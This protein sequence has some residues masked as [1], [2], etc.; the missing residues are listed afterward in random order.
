MATI[1]KIL[2]SPLAALSGAFKKPAKAPVAAPPPVVTRNAAAENAR[3]YDELRKRRG[4]GANELTGG[5]AE[6]VT[7]GGKVLLGQ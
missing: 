1:G 4:A 6:P 3:R 2:L 5:G 7:P